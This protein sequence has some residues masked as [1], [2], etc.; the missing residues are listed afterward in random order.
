MSRPIEFSK[1]SPL[2]IYKIIDYL[3]DKEE[4]H[5]CQGAIII[6]E[7][8]K[9]AL[10]ILRE[11]LSFEQL[12]YFNWNNIEIFMIGWAT[13]E[14]IKELVTFYEKEFQKK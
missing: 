11:E 14:P 13:G 12:K 7:S 1:E 9:E 5:E 4:K 3:E 2:N 6:A 10:E 8:E